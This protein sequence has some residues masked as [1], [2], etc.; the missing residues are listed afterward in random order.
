MIMLYHDTGRCPFLSSSY[1]L[2]YNISNEIMTALIR[3]TIDMLEYIIECGTDGQW[4]MDASDIYRICILQ[5]L[6]SKFITS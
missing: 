3:C 5:T 1:I 4:S 2:H 6:R